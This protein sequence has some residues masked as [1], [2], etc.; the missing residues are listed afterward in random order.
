M[1]RR[2]AT[3]HPLP[4]WFDLAKYDELKDI[5]N[6]ELYRE[7]CVRTY[8]MSDDGIDDGYLFGAIQALERG[9]IILEPAES[10]E[11]HDEDTLRMR[12][13][14]IVSV[15][16]GPFDVMIAPLP[17]PVPWSD[18][19][20]P[21]PSGAGVMAITPCDLMGLYGNAKEAGLIKPDPDNPEE[22]TLI[23]TDSFFASV[24]ELLD[25]DTLAISVFLR[26]S[27]DEEIIQDIKE[28]LPRWRERLGAPE[29]TKR[30]V[31]QVGSSTIKRII[32]YRTIPMLDLMM[33]AKYKG[34]EYSAEQ[35][36]RAI[37]PDD[38]VMGKH[39]TDTRIPFALAFAD[40]DYQ[41]M[42]NLWL[43]QKGRDG[44]LNRDRLARDEW[45]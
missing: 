23:K 2:S 42:V 10:A 13:S 24:S 44:K 43:R 26:D 38:L 7:V 41:D 36:A 34:F 4:K 22:F 21:L 27:T 37:F 18:D 35:L 31:G 20:P 29:P 33:W 28:L 16:P 19:Y 8:R 30:E 17:E 12:H 39:M 14:E 3:I 40:Y 25:L 32:E 5:K 11:Q 15:G 1:A 6:A 45:L 9:E